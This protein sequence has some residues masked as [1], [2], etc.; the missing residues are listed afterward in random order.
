MYAN[1]S[2]VCV[3]SCDLSCVTCESGQP[4]VC[5]SCQYGSTLQNGKCVVDTACNANN[6]CTNCGQGLNYFLVPVSTAGGHCVQCSNLSNCV[7]CNPNNPYR[8]LVCT[9]GYFVDL[10]GNCAKCLSNCTSCMSNMTCS[11]CAPGWTQK[12]GSS[13]S[14][15]YKCKS[16]CATCEGSASHCTS[17][18][19]GFTRKGRI[20]ESST[21]GMGFSFVL[22]TAPSNALNITDNITTGILSILE[23]NLTHIAI[24]NY[25]K[26]TETSAGFT[27]IVGKANPTTGTCLNVMTLKSGLE[28]GLPNVTYSVSNVNVTGNTDTSV[29]INP[30]LAFSF[31]RFEQGNVTIVSENLQSLDMSNDSYGYSVFRLNYYNQSGFNNSYSYNYSNNTSY[32]NSSSSYSIFSSNFKTSAAY[33]TNVSWWYLNSSIHTLSCNLFRSS[34][35]NLLGLLHFDGKNLTMKGNFSVQNLTNYPGMYHV[36]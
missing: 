16:P 30:E 20:C 13:D 36:G 24:V 8:C 23:Q 29:V 26:I 3:P 5:L 15:C 32:S 17:C 18:L 6:T 12:K 22:E 25:E 34:T 7:Q 11:S 19:S 1:S 28:A 4:S 14:L 33:R 2:G 10:E 35:S 9:R 27:L 21:G 31:T